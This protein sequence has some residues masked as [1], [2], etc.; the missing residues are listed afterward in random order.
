MSKV[1]NVLV[2]MT[3]GLVSLAA[4][5]VEINPYTDEAFAAARAENRPVLVDIHATWCSTCRRQ[6]QILDGLFEDEAL[7]DLLVLKLDWDAQREIAQRFGAPRQSTL[8]A[9]RGEEER[10]RSVADTREDSIKELLHR[11]VRD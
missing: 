10:G 11:A 6:A 8:I 1:R 5:A 7:A 4:G 3:L 9:F 2:A